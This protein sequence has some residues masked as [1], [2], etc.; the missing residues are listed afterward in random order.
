MIAKKSYF[1]KKNKKVLSPEKLERLREKLNSEKYI[2]F[3]INEIGNAVANIYDSE[4]D[5]LI[6]KK[7][8]LYST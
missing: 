4:D 5:S 8:A 6:K 3:A 1:Q 2:E 7:T